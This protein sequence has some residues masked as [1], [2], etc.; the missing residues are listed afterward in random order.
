[1]RKNI[2]GIFI[3]MLLIGSAIPVFG[4]IEQ[5][6]EI[7]NMRI[8]SFNDEVPVWEIGD[9]WTFNESINSFGYLEDGTLFYVWYLN[10]TCIYTVIDDTGDTYTL[11]MISENNEGIFN[12]GEF[13]KLKFT[14]F[15]RVTQEIEYRKE[16]LAILSIST[17]EKGL[18][19]WSFGNIGIPIPAYF[20][21]VWEK[22]F[23]PGYEYIPFPLTE[24]KT[25][26]LPSVMQTG[27]ETISLYFGLLKLADYDFSFET[28]AK[29]YICELSSISI[30][31]GNFDAFNISTDEGSEQNYSYVYYVP[32]VGFYAKYSSHYEWF[33]KPVL[34]EAYELIS[35][36][37]IP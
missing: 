36:T 26:T 30:P 2:I 15:Y 29:D 34:N 21:D 25:G 35:T 19:I 32:E 9:S 27:H 28:P 18:V 24:G 11:E 8:S 3:V 22:S 23:T 20:S 13:Y 5:N 33:E 10:C 17:Q 7:E 31:A 37:Y 16:D 4:A 12:W 14:P 6:L 1:M